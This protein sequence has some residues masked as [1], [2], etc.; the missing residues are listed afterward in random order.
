MLSKKKLGAK[1]MRRV[2]WLQIAPLGC[3]NFCACRRVKKLFARGFK[4]EGHFVFYKHHHG[5][6]CMDSH[7]KSVHG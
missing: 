3:T 6:G 4:W 2:S 7:S 5:H 1:I